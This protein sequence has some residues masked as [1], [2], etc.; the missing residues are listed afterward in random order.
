M[1][2]F[3]QLQTHVHVTKMHHVM[4]VKRVALMAVTVHGHNI[5]M[6][7]L[8]FVSLLCIILNCDTFE[9]THRPSKLKFQK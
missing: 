7:Y 4:L 2:M 5:K 1:V 8:L 3:V 6:Q 9:M